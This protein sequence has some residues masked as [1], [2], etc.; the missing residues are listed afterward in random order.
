M[1]LSVNP[2]L[3]R[4]VRYCLNRAYLGIDDT[5]LSADERYSL[6]TILSIIRQSEDNWRDIK[7][8]LN[9]IDNELPRIYREALERLPEGIVDELF[10]RLI[11]NCMDLDEVRN[12]NV[13][14]KTL[15][16]VLNKLNDVKKKF[17]GESKS[18]IYETG[19]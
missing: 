1:A 5:K 17:L 15:N 6:E 10:Q 7:D 16:D 2:L 13:V 12:D 18:R 4:F 9:F 11:K 19:T 14:M 3:Y 8:L